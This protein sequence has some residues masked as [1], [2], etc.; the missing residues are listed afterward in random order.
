MVPTADFDAGH[1][2]EQGF[3][4]SSSPDQ[5]DRRF[6][7]GPECSVSIENN[8]GRV[9]V[10]GWDRPEVH[11]QATKRHD[12]ANA[13]RFEETRI[14]AFKRD[15]EVIIRTVRGDYESRSGE[16]SLWQEL[17]DEGVRLLDALLGDR[18]PAEVDYEIKVPRQ[19]NLSVAVVTA[20]LSIDGVH[21]PVRTRSVSGSSALSNVGGDGIDI[22]LQTVSGSTTATGLNGTVKANAV[23]GRLRLSGAMESVRLQTVSGSVEVANSL[24]RAADYDIKGVSGTVQLAGPLKS[25]HVRTVSGAIEIAGELQEGGH[26]DIQTVSGSLILSLPPESGASIK[27][28]GVSASVS[29]DLPFEVDRDERKPGKRS[30]NGRVNG[31]GAAVRFNTVSGKLRVTRLSPDEASVGSR[32]PDPSETAQPAAQRDVVSTGSTADSPR[33][34]RESDAVESRPVAVTPFSDEVDTD[35][36]HPTEEDSD[37]LRV[38]QALERGELTVEEALRRLDA[39]AAT[40]D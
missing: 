9:M 34:E 8:R 17:A 28:R 12:A 19:A 24:A 31:G 13:A 39:R 35:A 33:V 22:E 3:S 5:V 1:G 37:Q 26:H 30:W 27:V 14:E 40:D 6:A 38:L 18:G 23:S 16:R 11:V 25:L 4:S 20:S 10:S 2:P 15:N 29:C 32:A 7:T 21:G 36:G